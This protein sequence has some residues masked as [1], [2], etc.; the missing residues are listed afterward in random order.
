MKSFIF[1]LLI[2]SAGSIEL[3]Q[4]TW[5]EHTA[6]KAVFVKFFA[7]WCGHCKRMKPAWDSLMEDFEDSE[8]VLVADVDC[9]EA[10]KSLCEKVGVKG[11]PTIKYGNPHDLQD[12]KGSRDHPDL[13]EF[14]DAL[15]PGCM[16]DTLEHCSEEDKDVILQLQGK[17]IEDLIELT[18][19]EA[20]EREQVSVKFKDEVEKLQ[21]QYE[22]LS[23][24][25][26]ATLEDI[27]KQYNIGLV[28][29]IIK[30]N[31]KTDL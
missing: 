29:Q 3:T 18:V 24:D 9:I 13:V 10:G 16:V 11:F 2:A 27:Q 31:E 20:N 30:L 6:G 23:E 1:S 15:Q 25:K 22:L 14:A 21:K 12:Y 5:D 19:S 17:S 7:P 4:D 28:K 26:E 8:T